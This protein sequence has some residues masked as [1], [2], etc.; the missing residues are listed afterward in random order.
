MITTAK[1][2][3][4][5]RTYSSFQK[6]NHWTLALLCFLEFPTAVGLQRAHLGHAFGIK[7]SSWDRFLAVSHEWAGWLILILGTLLLLSRVFQGAPPLPPGMRLWQRLL[8]YTSH[9][10]IYLGLIG[11]VASGATAMYFSGTLSFV[12]VTL[13]KVGIGLIS[14]HVAAALWH[15]LFRGDGLLKRLLPG[16]RRVT[17]IPT[18][19]RKL[20]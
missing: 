4:S 16:R 12:H 11:L 8:A 14:L 13:A 15:Q 7:A 2:R 9:T 19:R 6:A 3:P 17:Q 10:A 5:V 18:S 1:I 20:Q